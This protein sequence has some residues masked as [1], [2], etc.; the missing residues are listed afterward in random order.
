MPLRYD[1]EVDLPILNP[2]C[3]TTDY[4]V[5]AFKNAFEPIPSGWKMEINVRQ[6]GTAISATSVGRLVYYFTRTNVGSIARKE[7]MLKW[8]SEAVKAKNQFIEV[9]KPVIDDVH[10][11]LKESYMEHAR[12]LFENKYYSI[13]RSPG[14]VF[15]KEV[16]N[17]ASHIISK[18]I[19]TSYA[20]DAFKMAFADSVA[21]E[22][23]FS[24]VSQG[25]MLDRIVVFMYPEAFSS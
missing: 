1:M 4:M 21:V 14:L 7:L 10:S 17:N 22:L 9:L 12:Q 6:V 25:L 19:M 11:I 13:V 8:D 15:S 23:I 24:D 2:L 3:V 16:I 20:K 18:D 5:E